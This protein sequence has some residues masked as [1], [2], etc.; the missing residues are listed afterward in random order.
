MFPKR[1][2]LIYEDS[3]DF[4]YYKN[5]LVASSR[6]ELFGF[7]NE[8]LNRSLLNPGWNPKSFIAIQSMGLLFLKK[9]DETTLWIYDHKNKF[10][11]S[12]VSEKSYG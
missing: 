4:F 9:G 5:D 7:N 6:Q 11:T 3:A 2:F 1:F 10:I 8:R 12:M